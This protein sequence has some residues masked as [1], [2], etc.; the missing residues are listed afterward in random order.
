MRPVTEMSPQERLLRAHAEPRAEL[1]RPGEKPGWVQCVACAHRCPIGPNRSG[2]CRVRF[3]EDGRLRVPWGYTAGGFA[4]DPIEKKPFYHVLPGAA[5]LS[6]G[7]LGCNFHCPYCQNW[8][9]SQALREPDA[10]GDISRATPEEVVRQ[11]KLRRA[12]VVVSTYNEPLITSE[13]AAD[14]FDAARAAGLKTGMVSNGHATPETLDFLKPRLDLLK[15][16]LKSFDEARYRE[17]GG[18]LKAVLDGIAGALER[19]LWVEVVTLVVPG[20]NDDD[21]QLQAI[22]RFLASLSRDVPWHV[23]AFHP[24]FKMTDRPSTPPQTLLH[25]VEIGRAEGLRYVYPGN[26]RAAVPLESTFC[27]ECG[28]LLVEREG[29]FVGKVCLENGA[30]PKC[31]TPIPGVWR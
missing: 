21:P 12:T 2:I 3:N 15:I 13:W 23:T 17:L 20:F 1:S 6:F 9:I 18:K 30:C 31:K 16:D 19:G 7:M 14:V 22:A 28:E 4:V 11:A 25:A 27:P 26:L 10:G 24:R 5:T 8:N 29:F